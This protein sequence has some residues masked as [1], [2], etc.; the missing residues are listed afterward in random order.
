MPEL[1][2][3]DPAPQF[4][5]PNQDGILRS[6]ADYAGKTLVLYF[7][8][9]DMTPGCTQEACDVR[10][11]YAARS[12]PEGVVI[13][14]VSADSPERHRKFI[15]KEHLPFEL[16]SDE[17]KELLAAYGFWKE[18]TLYGKTFLG[19]ERATVVIRPDGTIRSMERKVKVAGHIA[20][21]LAD[22][23]GSA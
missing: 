22:L 9:R 12:V 21:V 14:G 23:R 18:K 19:I 1:R 6:L 3:G 5:L 7:Y 10:D 20:R 15:A 8:P 16:L 17:K 4:S 11:A 2:P 13:V